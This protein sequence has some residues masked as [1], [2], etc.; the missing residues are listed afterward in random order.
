MI[1]VIVVEYFIENGL[2]MRKNKYLQIYIK[3]LPLFLFIA[4]SQ[5]I[6]SQTID[7]KFQHINTKN[8]LSSSSITNIVQDKQGFIWIGTQDGLNRYDGYSVKIYKKQRG[9]S[10]SLVHNTVYALC[11]DSTGDLWIGT[12]RGL[13]RYNYQSDSFQNYLLNPRDLHSNIANRVNVIVADKENNVL[14]P[15]EEGFIYQYDKI[16]NIFSQIDTFQF[17]ITKSMIIDSDNNLWI[18]SNEGL[19][20]YNRINRS[21]RQLTPEQFGI[22]AS[23]FM[24]QSIFENNEEMWIGTNVGGLFIY[25]RKTGKLVQKKFK[26]F[27]ENGIDII[28]KDKNRNIWVATKGGLKLLDNESNKFLTFKHNDLDPN[29]L[30]GDSVVKIF[31]D[32]QGNLWFGS[33]LGGVDLLVVNKAFTHYN[34]NPVE[35]TGLTKSLVSAVLED[36]VENLWVGYFNDGID[37]INRKL[38]TKTYIEPDPNDPSRLGFGTVFSIF[39]DKT[40]EIWIGTNRGGLQKYNKKNKTFKTYRNDP[41]NK[42][43]ISNDDIRS[44]V[45]DEQ[46]NLWIVTHGAGINKFDRGSER[47]YQYQADYSDPAHSLLDNWPFMVLMDYKNCIWIATAMGLSRLNNDYRTFDNFQNN[48]QNENSLSDD[49]VNLLFEDS[50]KNLWV[51]T[52]N[53]LNKYDRKKNHFI[54][55]NMQDGLPNNMINGILEDGHGNL[56]ISTNEGLSRFSPQNNTF[57]NYDIYDGLQANEFLPRSCFK[58]KRGEMF[59]GGVNGLTAFY[60]HSIK[61]NPYIPPVFI[62]DIRLFNESIPNSYLDQNDIYSRQDTNKIH[63]IVFDHDENVISFEFVALNYIHPEKNQY[64]YIMEGFDK[65][66]SYVGKKREATYTNLNPGDYNFK[67]IAS[68]NDGIW[69]KTGTAIHIKIRPPFWQTTLFRIMCL[70]TLICII[71]VIIR[72]RTFNINQR[73]IQLEEINVQLKNEVQ[74]R[75]RAE[76]VIKVSLSEKEVLLK[77]LHHRVKNNL[78]IIRSLINL[79]SKQINDQTALAAFDDISKRIN[80]MALVHEKMY[81][82]E[83][84]VNINFKEYIESMVKELFYSYEITGKISLD[85]SVQNILLGL[86]IA[87]PSGLIINELVTNALKHAF[88]NGR[89]GKIKIFLGKITTHEIILDVAD[90][91]IGIQSA[92][93]PYNPQT[94]GLT[95]INILTRQLNGR[96]EIDRTAGSHFKIYFRSE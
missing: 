55:Y 63:T 38:G 46:N 17:R 53:G 88:P 62:T 67:V 14:A 59:F 19:F 58:N 57:R 23:Q 90:N 12:Q 8:G 35:N 13:S 3:I 25:N 74:E 69:N 66:W 44:I 83:N 49:I 78:Q 40:G 48:P 11:V 52:N 84:F 79:Q 71:F 22:P 26:N 10:T 39:E 54:R 32:I 20:F 16:N 43:S 75:K 85:L 41:D 34:H 30:T 36:R 89:N 68:N 82:S 15:S 76:D 65:A 70:I 24:I 77:E 73:N 18:G 47:F 6:A 60:P 37:I 95:L 9:D 86:D 21:V 81:K 31:Q 61:D 4:F 33:A 27:S 1:I 42:F 28:Y 7:L 51:G 64:A 80:S 96:L 56:W 91:G 45:E 5:V 93:D 2:M 29:S 72:I 94:L 92:I 50:K 87:I